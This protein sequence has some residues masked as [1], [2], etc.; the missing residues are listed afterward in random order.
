MKMCEFRS[1]TVKSCEQ[2]PDPGLLLG[3]RLEGPNRQARQM[4]HNDHLEIRRRTKRMG[5]GC[6]RMGGQEGPAKGEVQYAPAAG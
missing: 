6:S 1:A 3:L 4:P 2:P 5:S